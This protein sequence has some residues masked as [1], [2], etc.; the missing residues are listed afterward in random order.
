MKILNG[1]WFITKTSISL[2][3]GGRFISFT[4][5]PLFKGDKRGT[6]LLHFFLYIPILKKTIK[7]NKYYGKKGNRDIGKEV[8]KYGLKTI[9][10][11]LKKDDGVNIIYESE[12]VINN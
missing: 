7:I 8:K 6:Y 9:N 4:Y 2:N 3:Q 11:K 1:K 5:T 12:V 10:H